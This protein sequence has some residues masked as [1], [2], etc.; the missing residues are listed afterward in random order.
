MSLRKHTSIQQKLPANLE[1]KLEGLM[2]EVKTLRER[3]NFP[4]TLIIKMDETPIYFDMPR[5]IT[6]SKKD[7]K[8]VG[9][10][11]TKGGK[12]RVTYVVFCTAA[13]QMLKPMVI[14]KGTTTRFIKKTQ[15]GASDIVIT[16]QKRH[17]WTMF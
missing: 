10:R 13:G 17:G 1:K 5:S 2:A 8:E 7:A 14:F 4:V 9:I 12:K 6:V 16:F 11:G 3:H 15:K